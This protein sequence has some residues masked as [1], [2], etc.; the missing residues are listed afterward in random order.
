MLDIGPLHRSE[1]ELEKEEQV[2]I[3][4]A[5]GRIYLLGEHGENGVGLFL[6]SAINRTVQIAV[7]P[8]KDNSIRFFAA[9]LGERKRTTLTNL[10]YKREDRWAN[11]IKLAIYIFGAMGRHV[12]GLN[13]TVIGDIPQQAE[14]ASST[15]IEV[16]AVIALKSF[17]KVSLSDKEILSALLNAEKVF[18]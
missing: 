11:Y 18:L 16:A 7:S 6:A 17:F 3:A 14:L 8:R 12:K 5:P 2:V 10:K 13:C 9:D 1:Y 15:A 4:E